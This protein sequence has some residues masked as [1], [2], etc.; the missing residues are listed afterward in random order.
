MSRLASQHPPIQRPPNGSILLMV[1]VAIIIM[2]L[3][4]TTYLLLMRN[5][6]LAARYS[7]NHRQADSLAQSGLEYL[8]VWMAQTKSE[9]ELQGGLLN[10]PDMLQD[11]LVI[12][13]E[14]E[15]YRGRFT[16]VAPD[17]MQGYYSNVRYGVENE[18]AKLHLNSLVAESSP[19]EELGSSAEETDT[20]RDRLMLVPGMNEEVADAILDWLDQDDSPRTYGAEADYYQSLSPGYLPKNGPIAHLDELL[21]IQGVTP[22]LL[23]GIDTNRNYL[24]DNEEYPRGALQQLDN[25][26]QQ[27][28]RG[29]A[30]YLTVHSSEQNVT[31]EGEP[32]LDVNGDDLQTLHSSLQQALGPAEANFIIAYRQY[33]PADQSAS[34]EPTTTAASVQPNFE[35]QAKTDISTMLDLI[36]ATVSVPGEEDEPPQVVESPWQ[37]DPGT[38]QQKFATLLDVATVVPGERIAGRIN[39]NQASWPVLLTIPGMTETIADQIL[40]SRDP[41]ADLLLGDQR[42]PTWLIAE[43][44][45][46]LAELKPMFPYMTT[47][48]DV[49]RCQVVGFFDAGTA[50]SRVEVLLGRSSEQ[51][52]LLEWR[53][54]SRLGPGFSRNVLSSFVVPEDISPAEPLPD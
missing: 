36:D 48:G 47:G 34:S 38:Y 29:W 8:R 1:L 12:D 27:L 51:T 21:M 50:R 52:L 3:T 33:G 15:N 31:S 39:I 35:A 28:D 13:D 11:I 26:N 37:D 25:S 49:F 54:L 7:G 19:A 9:I 22:E 24:T 5:E 16:V 14:M 45:V 10:N 46:T 6:H 4:T 30:A 32:K 18:S 42:H 53:D 2:T 43:G 41:A 40:A 23:Y 44:L 20:A 17:M